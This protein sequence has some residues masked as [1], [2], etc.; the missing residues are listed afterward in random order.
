MYGLNLPKMTTLADSN[1]KFTVFLL[2]LTGTQ[3]DQTQ[4]GD[5]CRKNKMDK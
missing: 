4:R 1:V 2:E 5:K 3:T